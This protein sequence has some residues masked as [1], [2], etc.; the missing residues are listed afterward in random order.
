MV[1]IEAE[2]RRPSFVLKR[3]AYDARGEQVPANVPASLLPFPENAPDNRLGF[4][5]WL[6]DPR[7]PLTARVA[8]NRW[9]EMYFGTG[10]V[11]TTEDFGVQGSFPSHP[12]LLDWL[13]SE[14]VSN[15]WNVR[16]VLKKIALSATYRQSSH[17]RRDLA[18][19]DPSAIQT[20]ACWLAGHDFVSRPKRSETARS[21]RPDC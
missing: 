18:E 16:N 7:H 12:E 17:V 9:W 4:A 10:I 8:V 5:K 13:A 2:P 14:L 19:R 20:T 6:V 15:Q 1:M 21:T 11:E 3:G